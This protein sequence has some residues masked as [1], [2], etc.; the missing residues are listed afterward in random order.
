MA[1]KTRHRAPSNGQTA[2]QAFRD[3]V[4]DLRRVR[5]GDLVPSEHNWRTHPQ[6][7]Q[8]ALRGVL[9]EI[10]YADALL[11]RE[12]PDG[13]LTLV[14]GHLRRDLDPDQ[15]VPVL[16][17]DVDEAEAK[18]LLLTLDPLAAMAEANAEALDSLLREVDTGS[19]AV[20]SLLDG[21]ASQ[22]DDNGE[23]E[24]KQLST[25]PPPKMAWVLIGIPVVRFA[26]IAADVE[27]LAA[28][29]D[30]ILET[31]ANDGN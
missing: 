10:G 11:A 6:A 18:K 25:L 20:Q 12:L 27:R 7:Q 2:P 21:L 22:V 1:V 5:A 26:E 29:P 31:T 15:I 8:D 28:M 9:T 4:K 13:R 17:L 24:I 30:V 16:I 19:E 23:V 14:D 3:R